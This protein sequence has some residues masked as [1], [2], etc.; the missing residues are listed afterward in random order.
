M[1][2]HY[3]ISSPHAR[4]EANLKSKQAKFETELFFKITRNAEPLGVAACIDEMGNRART[5]KSG[6][7]AKPKADYSVKT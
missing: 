3:S 7:K 5:R 4:F 1:S 6:E 2:S